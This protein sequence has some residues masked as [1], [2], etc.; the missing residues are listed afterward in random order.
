MP[1]V[2]MCATMLAAVVAVSVIWYLSHRRLRRQHA[3][4][5]RLRAA[6]SELDTDLDRLWAAEQE[7]IRRY[8]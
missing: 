4:W 6:L 3:E 8:R 2:I 1:N 5:E 7:R